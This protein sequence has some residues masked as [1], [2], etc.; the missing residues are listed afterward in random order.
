M[1]LPLMGHWSNP[2][3]FDP[4]DYF[5]FIYLI[6]NNINNKRYVGR[7]QFKSY[8]KR[9]PLKGRK[10]KR[11]CSK[12]SD[13]RCY[14][15][16]SQHVLDDIDTY[17]KCNFKFEIIHLCQNKSQLAYYEPFYMY[18]FNVLT[19]RDKFG[20]RTFYNMQIPACRGIPKL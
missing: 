3:Q 13:W 9:P 16:S 18:K 20:N 15:S 2:F 4:E 12:D 8:F 1:V 10:N 5:G 14:C 11:H 17:G 19:E 7:K 6:T